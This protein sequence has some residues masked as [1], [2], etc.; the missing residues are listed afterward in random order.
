MSGTGVVY[1]DLLPIPEKTNAVNN[2][3]EHEKSFA[4]ADGE[5]A[6][7]ALA[8]QSQYHYEQ[9]I[10][11]EDHDLE[12]KNLGWN[13]PKQAIP[14]PLVGG[15]DNEEMWLL[16]RRFNKVGISSSVS[17]LKQHVILTL[18]PA[19]VSRQRNHLSRPWQSRHQ[20]CR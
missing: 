12:V 2:P 9:G 7:H 11:Q 4:L 5:T 13:E 17:L 15:M 6:S 10:A 18:S 14:S 8:T 3:D 1:K 16:V 19:N 20:Y